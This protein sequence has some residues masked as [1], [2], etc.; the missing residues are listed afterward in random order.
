MRNT[1]IPAAVSAVIAVVFLLPFVPPGYPG[2]GVRLSV[3]MGLAVLAI[4]SLDVFS[5]RPDR[6]LRGSQLFWK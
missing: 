6:F 1:I 3:R 4:R 5:A 2:G